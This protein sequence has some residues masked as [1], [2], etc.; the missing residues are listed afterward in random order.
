MELRCGAGLCS[1]HHLWIWHEGVMGIEGTPVATQLV[2]WANHCMRRGIL[3]M[4]PRSI[5]RD[6]EEKYCWKGG[7]GGDHAHR[8]SIQ[9]ESGTSDE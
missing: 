7:E 3:P 1:F 4:R 6:A 2:G 8:R 9:S 5:S